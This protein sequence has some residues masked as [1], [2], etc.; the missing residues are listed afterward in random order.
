MIVRWRGSCLSRCRNLAG[1]FAVPA[2]RAAEKLTGK[3]E[4]SGRVH[5]VSPRHAARKRLRPRV[6]LAERIVVLFENAFER[7]G[8]FAAA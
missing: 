1:C 8:D 6:S 4:P 3:L 7:I 5:L 2:A